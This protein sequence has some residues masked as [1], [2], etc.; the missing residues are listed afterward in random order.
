MEKVLLLKQ[1]ASLSA[2]ILSLGHQC[3]NRW[4]GGRCNCPSRLV[5]LEYVAMVTCC[6]TIVTPLLYFLWATSG[7]HKAAFW[8][9]IDKGL[10]VTK[11]GT[12]DKEIKQSKI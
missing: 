5:I 6:Y 2:H 11:E 3:P 7:P 1:C 8:W 10:K 12:V 4:N 9:P